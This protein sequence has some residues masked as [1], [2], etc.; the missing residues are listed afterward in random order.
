MIAAPYTKSGFPEGIANHL[1]ALEVVT[2]LSQAHRA[3][4]PQALT[5]VLHNVTRRQY[6]L[7]E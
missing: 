7:P 1:W 4:S 2:K 3:R 6:S 5:G